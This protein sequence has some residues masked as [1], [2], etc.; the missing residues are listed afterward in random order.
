MQVLL[1]RGCKVHTFNKQG[2]SALLACI[3]QFQ[4]SL[5]ASRGTSSSASRAAK[6]ALSRAADSH[7]TAPACNCTGDSDGSSSEDEEDPA[8][9][10][11]RE[12][13]VSEPRQMYR[14]SVVEVHQTWLAMCHIWHCTPAAFLST[15]L[16]NVC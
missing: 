11:G 13:A 10:K 4:P 1:Q 16:S 6:P 2:V 15:A 12:F 5:H 8:S 14:M 3:L 7:P 9:I